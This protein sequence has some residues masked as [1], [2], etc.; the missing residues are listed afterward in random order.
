MRCGWFLYR[1]DAHL[2]HVAS[3]RKTC[4][5]A[6]MVTAASG[7]QTLR[8]GRLGR[9]PAQGNNRGHFRRCM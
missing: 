4:G 6:L 8:I 7:A 5:Q 2:P 9:A 1:V 3:E